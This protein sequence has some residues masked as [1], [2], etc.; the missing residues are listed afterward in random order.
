MVYS[1]YF[2][3][4]NTPLTPPTTFQTTTTNARNEPIYESVLPRNDG[5]VS[6]PPLPAPPHKLRPKSPG[7][8]RLQKSRGSSPGPVHNGHVGHSHGHSHS[9]AH[10]HSLVHGQRSDSPHTGAASPRHSRPSSRSSVPTVSLSH[11]VAVYF[12]ATNIC[13][14]CE[15]FIL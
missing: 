2:V 12:C 11:L 15:H 9:H 3:L 14:A 8:E 6:P 4:Q 7:V 5:C 10:N 1:E 13:L